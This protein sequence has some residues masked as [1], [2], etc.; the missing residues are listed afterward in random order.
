MS[1]TFVMHNSPNSLRSEAPVNLSQ[2]RLTDAGSV[3][4]A[5]CADRMFRQQSSAIGFA[6]AMRRWA[7]TTFLNGVLRIIN[8]R[9][10]EEM[11]R[12]HA[13][14]IVAMMAHILAR[15][16]RP[17]MQFPRKARRDDTATFPTSDA[18]TSTSSASRIYPTW[19][20]FRTMHR[21]RSIFVYVPPEAHLWRLRF[22]AALVRDARI[23]LGHVGLLIRSMVHDPLV[24]I[25]SA[26]L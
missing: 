13:R 19:A 12:P 9:S 23:T 3:H 20:E 22:F 16:D 5:D 7:V 6:L 26:G 14:S 10:Q 11:S 1:P 25:A 21:D 2:L 4:P 15:W 8:I 18:E 17:I 24:F